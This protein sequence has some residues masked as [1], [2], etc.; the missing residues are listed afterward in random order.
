MQ[1][2]KKQE[3]FLGVRLVNTGNGYTGLTLVLEAKA[4]APTAVGTRVLPALFF[5]VNGTVMKFEQMKNG[6][7]EGLH[8]FHRP[9][10]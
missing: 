8:G 1:P 2:G 4:D 10:F 5:M 7:E 9:F 6:G 3:P